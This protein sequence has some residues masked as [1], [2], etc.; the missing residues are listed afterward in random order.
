MKYS[1]IHKMIQNITISI[2]Y[3]LLFNKL[4]QRCVEVKHDK[5]FKTFLYFYQ[6]QILFLPRGNHY[7]KSDMCLCSKCFYSILHLYISI[8]K[9][10]VVLHVIKSTLNLSCFIYHSGSFLFIPT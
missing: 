9:F 6:I 10:T 4:L 7:Y 2:I 5:F 3:S 1:H 8:N